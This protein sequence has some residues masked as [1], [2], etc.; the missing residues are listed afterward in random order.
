[1]KDTVGNEIKEI[2]PNCDCG[3]TSGCKKCNPALFEIYE[4]K[5]P[6]FVGCISD[7]EAEEM[8]EKLLVWRKK[9]NDNL[10]ERHLKLWGK[11]IIGEKFEL[12]P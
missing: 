6:S 12:L 5:L 8:K 1:M 10:N 3:L 11:T 7:E 4:N 2:M 9:F